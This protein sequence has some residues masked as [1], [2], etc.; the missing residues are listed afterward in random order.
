MELKDTHLET[1]EISSKFLLNLDIRNCTISEDVSIHAPKLTLLS[2]IN[3]KHKIISLQNLLSLTEATIT[4]SYS[5]YVFYDY[6]YDDL[7]YILFRGISQAKTI[8]LL[9]PIMEV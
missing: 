3:T 9:G 4:L 8:E 5:D 2:I 7:D 1:F 6:Y